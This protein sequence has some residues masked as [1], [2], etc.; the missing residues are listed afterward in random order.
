MISN[1][2]DL[3]NKRNG[4]FIHHYFASSFFF[5]F[6]ERS[7][8]FLNNQFHCHL[9]WT[10]WIVCV[11]GGGCSA[12]NLLVLDFSLAWRV[13]SRPCPPAFHP[14][15]PFLIP[16]LRNVAK[17]CLAMFLNALTRPDLIDASP[18]MYSSQLEHF[19]FHFVSFVTFFSLL[20]LK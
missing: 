2:I 17:C 10:G 16:S 15:L 13:R 7:F 19:I 11:E 4:V 20:R 3:K 6:I 5:F 18:T 8:Y 12:N 1:I 9:P 14:F